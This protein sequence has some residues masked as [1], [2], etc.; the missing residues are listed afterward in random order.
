MQHEKL[1]FA[2]N[3]ISHGYFILTYLHFESTQT[4]FVKNNIF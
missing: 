2:Q 1:C 3:N 4:P